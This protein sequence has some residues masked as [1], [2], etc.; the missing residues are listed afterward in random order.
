NRPVRPKVTA[1]EGKPHAFALLDLASGTKVDLDTSKLPG[2]DRD[3][4]AGLRKANGQ[5]ALD[6]PRAIA[7]MGA[8]WNPAGDR[9][10]L[11]FRAVDNKDRWIATVA[12]ADQVLTP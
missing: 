7:I 12:T 1:G 3:P 11:M 6:G 10:A 8:E 5:P 4:L 9:L 2:I